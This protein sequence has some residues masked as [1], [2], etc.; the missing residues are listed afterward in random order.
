MFFVVDVA[1]KSFGVKMSVVRIVEM[2]DKNNSETIARFR[3][4]VYRR[5]FLYPFFMIRMIRLMATA[6]QVAIEVMFA[7]LLLQSGV[8]PSNEGKNPARKLLWI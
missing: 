8:V 6:M 4:D 1:T 3:Y 2:K 7:V 5:D